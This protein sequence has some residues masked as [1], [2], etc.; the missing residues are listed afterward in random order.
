[1][2]FKLG[3]RAQVCAYCRFVVVRTDRGF[4][5]HGRVADMLELPSPF[6]V[7]TGGFWNRKRFDVEGRAQYDR[8]NAPSAPW[9]EF[10]LGF[11]EGEARAWV[12]SAQGRWYVTYETPGLDVPPLAQLR[13]GASLALGAHGSW[14]VQ[15]VGGRRLCSVE[16]SLTGIP[17]LNVVTG[18][19]DISGPDGRFGTLDYGDGSERPVVFLGQQFDPAGVVLDSGVPLAQAAAQVKD[20]Q[21]PTCGGNLPLVSGQAERI[22]CRFCGTQSDVTQ[23]YLT[24]LGPTPRST[25]QPDIALGAE[26]DLRGIRVVC[27][28]FVARSCLV[29]GE[30]Y[31][32]KEYL[33]WGGASVG[34]W[35]LV[36]EDGVWSLA[37]PIEVGEIAEGG[38]ALRFRG[39]DYRHA[40][41]VRARVDHVVGEFYWKVAIGESVEASE[42]TGPSGKVSREASPSEVVYSFCG[43]VHPKELVPF[44]VVAKGSPSL[45][46]NNGA[47][48]AS[49]CS[50]V[51]VI[52]VLVIG[53]LALLV[54]LDE[55]GGSF[56]GGS[57]GGG[58][59]SK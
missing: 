23:G 43:P 46:N 15:E 30:R 41:T 1:M 12:A 38:G 34:Y 29:E 18:F 47:P 40:Q 32:W 28:G 5:K 3:V 54:M 8:H 49:G 20:V 11:A 51:G 17:A 22:V 16:G 35:W 48:G 58:F 9:Q 33:L 37:T 42:Y 21:C 14:S 7:G 6:V 10:L 19:A 56:G 4:E 31:P 59:Y 13:P 55:C 25:V 2:T 57:F 45:G 39:E 44:G 36:E 24:A 27:C 50:S 53:V 26:A 52:I